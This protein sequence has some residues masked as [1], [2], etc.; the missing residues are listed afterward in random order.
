MA[1]RQNAAD[2]AAGQHVEANAGQAPGTADHA[3]PEASQP[4]QH[5]DEVT[6]SS[7]QVAAGQHAQG[8]AAQPASAGG[9]QQKSAKEQASLQEG[10]PAAAPA[11]QHAQS[12]PNDEAAGSSG[13]GKTNEGELKKFKQYVEK[14]GGSAEGW[15]VQARCEHLLHAQM[16]NLHRMICH[17]SMLA[18]E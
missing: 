16:P 15:E 5:T 6:P 1:D 18:E 7:P 3:R 8:L 10:S 2:G 13:A 9:G 14:L 12:Q 4:S 11:H 17:V